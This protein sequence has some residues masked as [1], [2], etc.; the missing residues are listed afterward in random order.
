MKYRSIVHELFHLGAIRFGAFPLKNGVVS[1]IYIDL[2]LAISHPKL[3]MEIAKAL[4]QGV[5]NCSFDL[6]C[7]VPYA[8]IPF[9]TA[10]S[11]HRNTPM[12]WL[13]KERKA[14]GT[15][16]LIEGIF[17]KGQR[18][19]VVE[20]VITEGKSILE[21]IAILE[22][23]GLVVRDVAVFVDRD[24][25]GRQNLA[26]RGYLLHPACTLTDMINVLLEEGKINTA[27]AVS[28]LEFIRQHKTHG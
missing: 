16:K 21:T 11:I 17:A 6:I 3:L 5:K 13:R 27:T 9:A 25:G 15:Q 2:R 10:L 12:I 4:E 8:A 22:R 23:E 14:Y 24:Q 26:D 1:P 19:L 7:G 28:T 18:C 20:D